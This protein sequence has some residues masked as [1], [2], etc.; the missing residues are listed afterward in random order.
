VQ[1][2]TSSSGTVVA[3]GRDVADVAVGDRVMAMALYGCRECEGC[4]HL[5]PTVCRQRC[6]RNM[7]AA[8]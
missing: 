6:G 7:D 1:L 8:E 5:R 4:A 3:V 2:A